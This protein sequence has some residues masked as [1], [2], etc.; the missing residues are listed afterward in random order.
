MEQLPSLWA[1]RQ[2]RPGL[3]A[4]LGRVVAAVWADGIDGVRIDLHLRIIV[5]ARQEPH[6]GCPGGTNERCEDQQ[7]SEAPRAGYEGSQPRTEAIREMLSL[8]SS[9]SA[10]VF[11][12][13]SERERAEATTAKFGLG[14]EGDEGEE[15]GREEREGRY[16][17]AETSA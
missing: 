8:S 13:P 9:A 3:E 10:C 1:Q 4:R 14:R 6:L 16:K 11:S 5:A 12:E 7:S 17:E 15:R 2:A